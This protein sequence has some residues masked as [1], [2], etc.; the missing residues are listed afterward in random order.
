MA[1]FFLVVLKEKVEEKFTQHLLNVLELSVLYLEMLVMTR[2]R[3][4]TVTGSGSG[5]QI[6]IE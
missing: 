3:F 2:E 4:G 1:A 6:A 5:T